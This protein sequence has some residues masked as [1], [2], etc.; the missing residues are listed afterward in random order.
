VS[1]RPRRRR[2]TRAPRTRP[3]RGVRTWFL[4]RW[5]TGVPLAAA[6]CLVLLLHVFAATPHAP[7]ELPANV[8]QRLTR[9]VTDIALWQRGW[10]QK[11]CADETRA[12]VPPC[13]SQLQE[14]RRLV[15][16]A[17][18]LFTG[19]RSQ[20]WETNDTR[21]ISRVAGLAVS[22]INGWTALRCDVPTD[23]Q[24]NCAAQEAYTLLSALST[25]APFH[26]DPA[27]W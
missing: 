6:L 16:D 13:A 7:A 5:L 26:L 17:E 9:A 1:E 23:L 19:L 27:A 20:G 14:G 11:G 12:F 2:A 21:E 3:V 4:W 25:A 18:N 22:A 15:A 10:E 8:A 24:C